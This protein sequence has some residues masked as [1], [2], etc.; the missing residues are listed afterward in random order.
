MK[1]GF[2]IVE[3]LVVIAIVGI[4]GL[5]VTEIFVR[6][7]RGNEKAKVSAN[8]KQNGQSVMERVDKVVRGADNIVCVPVQEVLV[9]VQGGLYTRYRFKTESG[10]ATLVED[11]PV[12]S[13]EV[14]LSTFVGDICSVNDYPGT[15]KIILTDI[16]AQ[17]GVGIEDYRF[18]RAPSPGYKDTVSI[19][20]KLKTRVVNLQGVVDPV[21]FRTTIGLR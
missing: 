9:V 2:T 13:G 1:R 18:L 14:P 19:I 11:N 16:S 7:L 12:F 15:N 10:V 3:V 20:F 6:S 5:V 21:E 4:M 17:G 8:I